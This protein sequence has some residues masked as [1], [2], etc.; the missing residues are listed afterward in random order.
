MRTALTLTTARLTLR[1][2][3]LADAD[4]LF[5]IRG[6]P[7][8]MKYWDWPGDP[9]VEQTYGVAESIANEMDAETALYLTARL[10]DG[11][12]VGLFDLSEIDAPLA[13]LGFMVARRFWNLGYATEGARRMVEEARRRGIGGLKARVH[14]GNDASQRLLIR[15]GFQSTSG[16]VPV[17]VMPGRSVLCENFHLDLTDSGGSQGGASTQ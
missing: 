13:D 7:E 5:L 17:E 8:A 4:E 1:R 12:F 9:S 11:T 16:P 6:D 2:F 3:D 10:G 14:L 15:L